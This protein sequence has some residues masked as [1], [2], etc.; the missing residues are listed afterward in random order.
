M[1]LTRVRGAMKG[2]LSTADLDD[3]SLVDKARKSPGLLG[4]DLAREV[5][6]R[7]S[8]TWEPGLNQQF[9]FDQHDSGSNRHPA[10][11]PEA[12]APRRPHVVALD[13]GMN[14][15]AELFWLAAGTTGDGPDASRYSAPELLHGQVTWAA[16]QYSLATLF[17]ELL[18]G[19]HPFRL[20]SSPQLLAAR[21]PGPDL[22]L[23]PAPDRP[24]V[25]KAL[26]ATRRSVTE[27]AAS[28]LRSWKER[29]SGAAGAV[30]VACAVGRLAA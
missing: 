19:S 28:S 22:E 1:R 18:V 9:L 24:V 3:A 4:R 10:G 26:H 16:D 27:A 25:A 21:R 17:Q 2:I 15:L 14:G 12:P 5:M 23:S 20:L 30:V 8:F 11:T 6:P 13:F 7:E 29:R